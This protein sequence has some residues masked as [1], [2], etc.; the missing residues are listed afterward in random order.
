MESGSIELARAVLVDGKTQANVARKAGVVRQRVSQ[1]VQNMRRYIAD[2]NPVPPGWRTDT[3]TLPVKD[4]P[5]VRALERAAHA[6]LTK[7]GE[8]EKKL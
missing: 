1:V 6:A 8:K 4:W 7:Q 3:V 5:K 2:A